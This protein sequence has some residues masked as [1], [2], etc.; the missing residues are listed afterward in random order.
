M[1]NRSEFNGQLRSNGRLYDGSL[2]WPIKG[3][4]KRPS[5]AFPLIIKFNDSIT[6]ESLSSKPQRND[7]DAQSSITSDFNRLNFSTYARIFKQQLIDHFF[8]Q[9][10]FGMLSEQLHKILPLMLKL[11][12]TKNFEGTWKVYKRIIHIWPLKDVIQCLRC[13]QNCRVEPPG[14]IT[15]NNS[16]LVVAAD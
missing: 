8:V 16:P 7:N 13:C 14:S 4:I 1:S 2:W 15:S 5:I 6:W 10:S 3:K 12:R 9:D 11:R